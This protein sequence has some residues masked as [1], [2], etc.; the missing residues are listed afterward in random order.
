MFMIFPYSLVS[1]LRTQIIENTEN[2]K[3]AKI[4]SHT[5]PLNPKKKAYHKICP[6]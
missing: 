5:L 6:N 4:I 1:Y 2:Q 3:L